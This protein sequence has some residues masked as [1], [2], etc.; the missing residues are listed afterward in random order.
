M[1]KEVKNYYDY[2]VKTGT[3]KFKEEKKRNIT[4]PLIKIMIILRS[5][6]EKG[7]INSLSTQSQFINTST[8][9]TYVSFKIPEKKKGGDK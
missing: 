3:I 4:D 1:T 8:N 9:Y 7:I 2:L 6:N 5:L